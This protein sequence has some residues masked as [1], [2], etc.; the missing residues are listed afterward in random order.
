MLFILLAG[1]NVLAFYLLVYL[2]AEALGPGDDA[3][4]Q[5]KAIAAVSLSLWI[6]VIIWGRLIG[7][8]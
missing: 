6:G 5:A 2:E 4:M 1:I 7:L 3:G 8:T